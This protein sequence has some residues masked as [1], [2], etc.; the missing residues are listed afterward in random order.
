MSIVQK[1]GSTL[2]RGESGDVL[3]LIVRHAL[4]SNPLTK[5]IALISSVMIIILRSICCFH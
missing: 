5:T 2:L 3:L 1:T 4:A